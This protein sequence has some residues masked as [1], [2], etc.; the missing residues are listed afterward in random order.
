MDNYSKDL[1]M[2][3]ENDNIVGTK[4]A[5]LAHTMGDLTLHRAFSVFIFNKEGKL[6]IQ[7]RSSDKL[8]YPGLWSNSCCSHP[9][10]NPLS[11]TNP[12][13]D[14]IN[15]AI[16]RLNYELNINAEEKDFCF[17]D[18][19]LYKATLDEKFFK[20]LGKEINLENFKE[21]SKSDNTNLKKDER[22]GEYEVDYLFILKN[23]FEFKP[24]GSEVEEVKYVDFDELKE[25]IEEKKV[26]PWFEMIFESINLF[27][28]N[29]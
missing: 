7:K 10:I 1:V 21:F 22:F 6:L 26:T 19:M 4:K 5:L 2:V 16:I 24:R 18:R 17:Y 20:F 27:D 29:K 3:N 15:H 25:L 13:L 14:C 11:F 28:L 12:V 8:V 9:F 23:D